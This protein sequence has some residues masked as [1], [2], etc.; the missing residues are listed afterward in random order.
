MVLFAP[1]R[2]RVGPAIGLETLDIIVLFPH[3]EALER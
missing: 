2:E 3:Q 1:I